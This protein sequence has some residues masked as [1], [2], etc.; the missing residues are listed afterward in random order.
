[1]FRLS[2]V[3]DGTHLPSHPFHPIAAPSAAAVSLMIGT[4]S[5]RR[6]C[7]GCDPRRRTLSEQDLRRRL[8]PMLGDKL[9][10]VLATYQR[11]RPGATPWDLFIA[12]STE[13][14]RIMSIRLA[15]EGRRRSR[16][17]VPVSVHLAIGL[18]GRSVQGLARARDPF[19]F[20]NVAGAPITGERPDRGV[21]AN[22]LSETW[23]QFA[24]AGD[25]NHAGIPSWRPYTKERRDTMIL[26]VPCRAEQAPRQ[27]ELDAWSDIDVGA[28]HDIRSAASLPGAAPAQRDTGRRG[29]WYRD[30][31][32][33]TAANSGC[34]HDS[35]RRPGRTG[36]Q[37]S[38]SVF[39]EHAAVGALARDRRAGD[40]VEHERDL[41][42]VRGLE[43]TAH[44]VRLPGEQ[45]QEHAAAPPS[46]FR[47]RGGST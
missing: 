35:G 39:A 11:T 10:R 17:R 27:E 34:R 43:Q 13:P 41:E 37:V 12:I 23:L 24:R 2:P 21:L 3:V 4:N 7:R 44:E 42:R 46:A 15:A 33:C 38:L 18:H 20:D 40:V 36:S 30:A 26:D 25:P 8:T 47:S 16:R 6:R 14:T 9:E 19:V 45:I 28:E 22:T 31:L 29:S 32:W 5:T 1:M